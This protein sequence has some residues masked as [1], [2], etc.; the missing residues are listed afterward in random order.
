MPVEQVRFRSGDGECGADLYL[1]DDLAAGER[2]AAIVMGSGFA[3]RKESIQS[4]AA[5]FARHGYIA[6]AIDYR[7][8]GASSGE[9]RGQVMPLWQVEDYRSAV[10]YLENRPDVDPDRLGIWGMSFAGGVVL[11]AAA[12]EPRIKAVVS[13]TPVVNGWRWAQGLRTRGE[14]EKLIGETLVN[15]RRKRAAGE[16]SRKIPHSGAMYAAMPF[17]EPDM[18]EVDV[19]REPDG[20]LPMHVEPRVTL[21]S[22][23]KVIEFLPDAVVDRIAPRAM[24]IIGVT[25]FDAVHPLDHI[26]DAYRRAGEPKQLVLLP[27]REFGVYVEPGLTVAL[28]HARA[29]FDT[30]L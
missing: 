16:P 20:T 27:Y 2:R 26:Q 11:Y 28:D 19:M 7:T 3:T 17:S 24:C 22:L 5:Y 10:T 14:W 30:H 6:L 1:P 15:D 8:F 25:G 13:Q 23:E 12:Y 18:A 29:W 4:Q 9:P 21:E